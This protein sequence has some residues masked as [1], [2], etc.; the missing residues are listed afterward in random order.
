MNPNDLIAKRMATVPKSGIRKFFDIVA[1][2]KDAISLGV[3][4]PDFVTPWNIRQAG[5]RSL[6]KGMTGYT[7]NWGTLELRREIARYLEGRFGLTYDPA[8]QILV[9][10]GAS[11]AID[12][13]LRALLDPGDEVLIPDPGYVSYAPGV[14]FAN[15]VPVSIP[16]SADNGF[17]LTPELILPRITQRTKALILPF[18]SNPTGGIMDRQSLEALAGA[19]EGTNIAVISDEI[20]A[21]LTYSGKHVSIAQLPSMYER[22]IVINGFSKAFAMTGWRL[23][24]LCGHRDLVAAMCKIHQYSILCAST[25]AQAAGV[26]ALKQGRATDYADV[27]RMHDAYDL[28]RRVV[29]NGFNDMGLPC[30]EPEGAFYAFPSIKGT[31]LSSDEFCERLLRE[32]KVA[33]VPGSAFG[34][35]GEGFIRCSYATSMEQLKEALRRIEDFVAPLLK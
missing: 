5:M 7:S 2:M 25:M 1:E 20:Y 35:Q 30:Y 12:L 28:R 15:A 8:D 19:L 33:A 16:M 11:E 32:K 34:A 22:T 29:V 9:T 27:K 31:G 14:V 6:E 26:E 23:G 10:I 3:G 18:P 17:K 21:E 4:E 13:A 24:Y